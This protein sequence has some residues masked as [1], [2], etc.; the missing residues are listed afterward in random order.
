M[1]KIVSLFLLASLI[2]TSCE[3]TDSSF[4]GNWETVSYKQIITA[5][6]DFTFIDVYGSPWQGTIKIDDKEF[7]PSLFNYFFDNSTGLNHFGSQE[8]TFT[9]MGPILIINYQGK[10][11]SL[12]K[13]NTFNITEGTYKIDG[14]AIYQDQSIKVHLDLTMPKVPLKKGEQYSV[15]GG[16]R[17]IPYYKLRFDG[18]G[19]L[20][21]DFLTGDIMERLSGK[22]SANDGQ[23]SIS[24]KNHA[25]DTYK[26]DMNANSLL[27]SKDKI[28]EEANPPYIS[29][30]TNK[31]SRITYQ[32]LY[33]RE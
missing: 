4:I 16:Y 1:K 19:K 20:R 5:R 33:M 23:L 31:I 29:P 22:W 25:K 9:F 6:E 3:K 28:T 24:V 2:L 12:Q 13:E 32:A 21:A 11:Y 17:Y 26:Y 18:G 15:N 7:D 8:L 30:F 14:T 27:L 10:E